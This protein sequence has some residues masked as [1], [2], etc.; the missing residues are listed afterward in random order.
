[1]IFILPASELLLLEGVLND[2]DLETYLI[3]LFL[4]LVISFL[5]LNKNILKAKGII[6]SNDNIIKSSHLLIFSLISFLLFLSFVLGEVGNLIELLTFSEKYR[7]GFY[8]GSGKYTFLIL[9]VVPALL[10]LIMLKQKK[11]DKIFYFSLSLVVISSFLV[12]LRIF[13]YSI[14]F[15]S[16]IRMIYQYK[17]NKIIIYFSFILIFLFS[18]KVYLNNEVADKSLTEK[19]IMLLA[20]TNYRTTLESNNFNSDVNALKGIILP[21]SLFTDISIT[22][23]KTS[24]VRNIDNEKVRLGLPRLNSYA[25]VAIPIGVFFYNTSG[26]AIGVIF[27]LPVLLLVFYFLYKA[28]SCNEI[29]KSSVYLGF[30]ISLLGCLTEDINFINKIFSLTII[31]CFLYFLLRKKTINL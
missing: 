3:C 29:F 31:Y 15:L 9:N 22:D 20:R 14:V 18:F 23:F 24:F 13:L 4:V 30:F 8:K 12:G 19:V 25:G 17:L 11:I 28:A 5:L 21:I 6:M 2:G 10:S 27:L 26:G 16:I 1:M 7:N